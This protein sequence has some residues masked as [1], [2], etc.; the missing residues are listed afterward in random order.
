[1]AGNVITRSVEPGGLVR[2]A[3][4][5]GEPESA[6]LR[7]FIPEGQIGQVKVGQQGQVYLDSFLSNRS[8]NGHAGRSQRASRRKILISKRPSYSGVWRRTYL[9]DPQGLAAGMPADGRIVPEAPQERSSLPLQW[10][11]RVATETLQATTQTQRTNSVVSSRDLRHCYGKQ[12]Q[13]A[14]AASADI[15]QG[16]ILG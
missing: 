13:E 15:Y 12:D 6:Y 4:D 5:A 16:E 1:M 10:G 3:A 14:V 11:S 7:G 8:S 2:Q 9:K